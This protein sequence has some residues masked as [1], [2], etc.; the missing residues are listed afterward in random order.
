MKWE[1]YDLLDL[2]TKTAHRRALAW[3]RS[4][5]TPKART[6]WLERIGGGTRGGTGDVKRD[7]GR[8]V[9]DNLPFSL[10]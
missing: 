10:S 7:D 9:N 5:V 3:G 8:D 1:I 6:L 4:T 2:K